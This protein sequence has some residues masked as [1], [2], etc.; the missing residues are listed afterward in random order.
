MLVFLQNSLI[1]AVL[2]LL[3]LWALPHLAK[4]YSAR[5]LYFVLVVLAVGFLIPVRPQF[6]PPVVHID[7]GRAAQPIFSNVLPPAAA[8]GQA[9]QPAAAPVSPSI[10]PLQ[11][12]FL[13]WLLGCLVSLGARL[14][15]HARFMRTL[16]RWGKP[17]EDAGCLALFDAAKRE[18]GVAANV[19]LCLFPFTATP[20]LV[21]F[22]RPRI[23]LQDVSYSPEQLRWVFHHELAHYKR[24]DLWLKL[25]SLVVLS[26][27]WFNPVAYL[28]A[29]KLND[30]CEIACDADVTRFADLDT[31]Q[32]YSETILSVVRKQSGVR[33]ALST[34]FNGSLR[35]LKRRLAAIM[36]M[37]GKRFGLVAVCAVLALSLCSGMLVAC[38]AQ[39]A[40]GGAPSVPPASSAPE[41][42]QNTKAPAPVQA[43]A[44]GRSANYRLL[45]RLAELDTAQTVG[46][47]NAAL[48]ATCEEA[49][50]D[51]FTLMAEVSEDFG[52][53]V[54]K[55]PLYSFWAG[56]LA[57]SSSEL[58]AS[59]IGGQEEA[60]VSVNA[61]RVKY[62]DG[63][64]PQ[65]LPQEEAAA[66]L[67]GAA[68]GQ[69]NWPV[70]TFCYVNCMI[71]YALPD[72]E[73][74]TVDEREA[75]F[76]QIQNGLQA[77]I[78]GLDERAIGTLAEKDIEPEM[79]RIIATN[80]HP[81]IELLGTLL[82]VDTPESLDAAAGQVPETNWAGEDVVYELPDYFYLKT[83]GRSSWNY[84]NSLTVAVPM[85]FHITMV[86]DS[87]AAAL[88]IRAQETGEYVLP[89]RDY[90]FGTDTETVVLQ[91][92]QYDIVCQFSG[93]Y[94]SLVV[95]G[96]A[97]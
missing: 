47:Y 9:V 89:S 33:S 80:L 31:R 81:G 42:L 16:R 90:A 84:G 6:A 76:A 70:D 60:F 19:G 20:M 46:R 23:L 41:A 57:H 53:D 55:D 83:E 79:Q 38:T 65:G 43:M 62:E 74:L 18:V 5:S 68:A 17:V 4:R 29:K 50:T 54:A 1:M 82:R 72:P 94:G 71:T 95:E 40:G 36:D 51:L 93:H 52:Q 28:L 15:T 87:G 64:T 96:T 61:N 48:A 88:G 39:P 3:V 66:L 97:V 11:L 59:I 24:R 78:N 44:E 26:V 12:I 58:F 32:V 67:K 14:F 35:G 85:S 92:G 25:L 34:S 2:A 49:G 86:T 27:Q 8:A 10:T 75:S 37:R 77:H 30:Q 56:T 7:A 22:V 21:G 73:A 69:E 91:P 63:F 45:A 13:L